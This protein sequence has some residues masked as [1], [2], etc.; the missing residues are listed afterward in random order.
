MS[1]FQLLS[2]VQWSLIE[3]L[4]PA[5]TGKK[6]RPFRDAH[7]AGAWD[8]VLA[9]LLAAAE[10]AGIIDWAV[11]VDSTIACVRQHATNSTRDTQGGCAELHESAHRAA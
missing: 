2:D 4:L 9:R 8:V 11:T 3:D 7:A 10:E 6:G 5:R 1:R